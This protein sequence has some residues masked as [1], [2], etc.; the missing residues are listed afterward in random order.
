MATTLG[1]RT[2]LLAEEGG[3]RQRSTPTTA[4]GERYQPGDDWDPSLPYGGKVYLARKR[5]KDP[6]WVRI[7]EVSA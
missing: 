1:D 3:L 4:P 6:L 2:P 7:G 5:I